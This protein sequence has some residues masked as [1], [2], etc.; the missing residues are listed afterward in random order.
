MKGKLVKY[1]KGDCLSIDC[2]NGSFIAAFISEK[3]NKYYDFTL[4]E[5]CKEAKPTVADFIN[6]RFFG[7]FVGTVDGYVPG[8]QKRL[9]ECLY[10]DANNQV[11]KIGSISLLDEL[12]LGGYGYL[13][14]I[15]ELVDY[16]FDDIQLRLQKTINVQRNPNLNQQGDRLIEMNVILKT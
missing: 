3:F 4:I 12:H 9:L 10:I 7:N 14:S 11:E 8:V 5:F 16:Y 2:N 15:D 13:K 6:G 1:R